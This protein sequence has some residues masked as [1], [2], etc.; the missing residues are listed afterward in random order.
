MSMLS[1]DLIKSNTQ[2]ICGVGNFAAKSHIV[3]QSHARQSDA[4]QIMCVPL[5]WLEGEVQRQEKD[6]GKYSQKD[7]GLLVFLPDQQNPS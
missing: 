4:W 6:A 2:S 1:S 3:H 5:E 7:S